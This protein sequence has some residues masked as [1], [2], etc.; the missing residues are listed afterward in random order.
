MKLIPSLRLC[1]ALLLLFLFSCKRDLEQIRNPT[2]LNTRMEATLS[3]TS[4]S[5]GCVEDTDPGL[6]YDS[7]PQPTRLGQKL[8]GSPFSVSVM[9]QASRNLYGTTSGITENKWYVRFKPADEGQLSTLNDMDLDLFDY[10]LDYEIIQEG[11]YYDN[12]SVPAE[13]IPWLYTV[14]DVGFTPPAGITY[15]LL[16]RLHVPAL[17]ALEREALRITSNLVEDTTC[18]GISVEA[19]PGDEVTPMNPQ[20]CPDGYHWDFALD[21]CIPDEPAPPQPAPARQPSGTVR[22]FDNNLNISVPVRNVRVIAKRF[23]KIERTYTNAQG[24]Y[25]ITK[26]FNKANIYIRTKNDQASIRSLRRARLWQMLFPAEVH[27]GKFKGSLNNLN[28]VI[29]FNQDALSEGARNWAAASAHNNVQEYYEFAAQQGIG[30][31]PGKIKVLITN[32]RVQGPRGAAPM[33]A[34]RFVDNLPESF[35]TQYLIYAVPGGLGHYINILKKEI[36]ITLGY[37]MFRRFNAD[38]TATSDEVGEVMFH[39]LTHAAHYNKVGNS[40]WNDFVNA[41]LNQM[42]L[43][44]NPPYGNGNA[45]ATSEIIA[46]GESWAYHMGHFISDLKYTNR[47]S[48]VLGQGFEYQNGPILQG[49][50]TVANT[51]LNAHINLL[52][53]FNTDRT[54][55]PDR[56]IPQGLYYDLLDNR[57]DRFQTP[58]RVNIDDQVTNYTNAQFFNA[59]D[60][61]V[62]SLR[63]YQ[64]RLLAESNNNQ[65][66]GVNLIFDFYVR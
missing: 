62:R 30:T 63:V 56:W 6:N 37:N 45:G 46:L 35:L 57:N 60:N 59:L 47:S 17:A 7:I 44:N 1:L 58:F 13:T 65:G 5:N 53:D 54:F 25:F 33:F 40:W 15:E 32:W 3:A 16:Q 48:P 20:L 8:K 50:W 42:A 21:R 2:T 27:F 52:E 29:L 34:K 31:P 22:V 39:E 12:G 61:D 4:Y 23:L 66:P 36:D 14:V 51:G 9:Q 64:A 38:Q 26:E 24:Q 55:D 28:H 10:P 43:S 11:D 41:E 19:V 18:G 49:G